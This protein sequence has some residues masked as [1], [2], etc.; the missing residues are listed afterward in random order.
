MGASFDFKLEALPQYLRL[1]RPANFFSKESNGKYFRICRPY[2][3]SQLLS[4]AIAT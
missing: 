1:L 4:S 2:S 3:V